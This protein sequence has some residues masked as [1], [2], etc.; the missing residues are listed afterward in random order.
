MHNWLRTPVARVGLGLLGISAVLVAVVFVGDRPSEAKM[1]M[2]PSQR[3]YWEWVGALRQ[4]A[5]VSVSRGIALLER[6]PDL[7]RLYLRLAEVCVAQEAIAV[8]K[9]AFAGAQSPDSLVLY[10]QAAV[11]LLNEAGEGTQAPWQA[12]ARSPLLDPT[13]ARLLVDQAS[14]PGH[15][16]WLEVL[17]GTWRKVLAADSSAAGASF[18][19]G[20]IAV[21][22]QA[23]D[24]AEPLL[25]RTVDLR[26]HDPE[27]Y[28]ELGRLYFTTGRPEA[29]DQALTAGIRVAAAQYD[30]E[31]EL[32]LRGNL[33][34]VLFQRSGDLVRAEEQFKQA[35]EQ[36]RAL[37][38]GETEGINLY[39]L[40]LLRNEQQR[41]DEALGLLDVAHPRYDVYMPRRSP[42]VQVLRGQTLR[43][44]FRFS[45]AEQ[46]LM[47]ALE[48]ARE[49]R[50]GGAEIQAAVA[51][52]QLRYRMGRYA[53][54]RE[55]G[56]LALQL[57][58]KKSQADLEIA[59]RIILGDVERHA[60][61]FEA[62]LQ[63]YQE[64]LRLAEKT[65]SLT[66]RRELLD[67][68][69]KT[70]L[71]LQNTNE[72][73][74]YFDLLLE[75]V[76]ASG[77]APDLA[78]AYLGLG[79]TYYQYRNFEEALRYYDLG[80]AT[81]AGS[82]SR[83]TSNLL[84]AR[85][86][87]LR[88]LERYDE[89][90][91]SLYE[92]EAAV[93]RPADKYQLLVALANVALGKGDPAQALRH[94]AAAQAIG[95]SWQWAATHWHLLHAKAI[96]HWKRSKLTAAER[97]FRE[98]IALLETLRGG[99]DVSE[100]RA[101]FVQNREIVYANFSAFLEEQGRTEEALHYIERARSR[102]LVDLLY[103]VQRERDADSINPA[104]RAIEMDRRIRALTDEI[105]AEALTSPEGAV[106][107]SAHTLRAA[108]LRRE[109][110]RADSVYRL[111]AVDLAERSG[112]Y[113]FNPLVTDG[114][115]ATLEQG[116]A[117]VVYDLRENEEGEGASVAYVV[118]ADTVMVRPLSVDVRSL[119]E[120]V[121][122]FRD[123]ISRVGP[124]WKPTARRLHDQLL[125]PVLPL[126]PPSITHLHLVPEGV[127]HYLP[128]AALLDE[129][130][131]F[132]AQHYTLSVTPSATI[133]K[134]SRDRNPRRW[135]S[136]LLLADPEGRLPG[137]RRE[138]LDIA[139]RSPNRRIPLVGEK[140]TQANLEELAGGYDVLHLATHG[141]F[142][143]QAPWM[144][145][146]EMYDGELR[147]DEI[148]R[149]ELDAYLV[150]LSACETG[151]SGG[152][153]S[154]MPSGEEWIGLHQAFLAAG[155]PTVM[156]SLWPIDDRVSSAFM[157]GFYEALGSEGKAFALAQMQRRFIKNPRT[158]HPFFWAAFSI[159]GDPL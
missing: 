141:R 103:T 140:A 122:F 124:R 21:R 12:I 84:I 57:A 6:Y 135:R 28:R 30:L 82:L 107:G 99:L 74:R 7:R 148:G 102:S 20:Y 61:R 67:R 125:A 153:V 98:S 65:Q 18:G 112:L 136:M 91:A 96:A 34:W 55:I 73:Q 76:R 104:S 48:A 117:M 146:L 66:R 147:V 105:M 2:P 131:A 56:L 111:A 121:R 33:G 90:E 32:I 79:R 63:H 81:D 51:L 71:N 4:E 3:A 19:I 134:L 127:L 37:A 17:D 38:D 149:L 58:Q 25:L 43:G 8:C 142:V 70:S 46:D 36:S 133:L 64:G 110:M 143:R 52:A 109:L 16:A 1:G 35:I 77:N 156:A 15:E 119:V 155:A 144:S 86:W 11:A 94:I 137:S 128:F 39:R 41:Y 126:L 83:R 159:I 45:E 69:G 152:L 123:E 24:K 95:D 89:A 157:S 92:A 80:L 101:Y 120:S 42:E 118:L 23:W 62:A 29:F 68:L 26:P 47:Q 9:E 138:V 114:V 60:G 151:L 49:R 150:T 31:Q 139:D 158:N 53:A 78:L 72:A 13:L 44:L 50:N 14:Q 85:A 75:L 154:D 93:E 113:T 10:R 129:R 132:L 22:Q 106:P 115:Q 40:A 27:A 108:T 97:A 59:S 54:A 145:Y 87:A 88:H 100:D 130:G 116:E 5:D